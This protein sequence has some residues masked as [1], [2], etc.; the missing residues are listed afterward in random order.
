MKLVIFSD[1]A[2]ITLSKACSS[3]RHF[4]R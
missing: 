4:R 2:Y 1:V 3:W